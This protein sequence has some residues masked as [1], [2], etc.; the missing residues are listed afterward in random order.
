MNTKELV[1]LVIITI[2]RLSELLAFLSVWLSVFLL[3]TWK[4]MPKAG[5]PIKHTHTFCDPQQKRGLPLLMSHV[6][7]LPAILFG[8]L[9]RDHLRAPFLPSSQNLEN[10]KA[11]HITKITL[12][13]WSPTW[14]FPKQ[15]TSFSFQIFLMVKTPCWSSRKS[16]AD[17]PGF[18][19]SVSVW[20]EKLPC[21][22][23]LSPALIRMNPRDPPRRE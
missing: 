11:V 3:V 17:F 12:S 23:P 21:F 19:F 10:H 18:V 9:F 4:K 1:S 7:S 20:C 2:K 8:V 13:L 16:F 14:N 6:F 22:L 5:L 15:K